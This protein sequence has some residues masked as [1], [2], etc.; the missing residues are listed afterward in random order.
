[1]RLT[2]AGPIAIN[3]PVWAQESVSLTTSEGRTTTQTTPTEGSAKIDS[4]ELAVD[5]DGA[6][7]LTESDNAF[8]T[9]AIRTTNDDVVLVACLDDGFDASPAIVG[10]QL[11]LRGWQSLYC[12]AEGR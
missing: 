11:F 9:V 3:A 6:V 1:M 5:A 4:P 12:I 2:S 10:K 7:S 8:T